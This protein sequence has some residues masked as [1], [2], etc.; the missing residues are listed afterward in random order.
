[1]SVFQVSWTDHRCARFHGLTCNPLGATRTAASRR[2]RNAS[3][4]DSQLWR[5]GLACEAPRFVEAISVAFRPV[6]GMITHMP[7]R[8]LIQFACFCAG[9]VILLVVQRHFQYE[10]DRMMS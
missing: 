7:T 6:N 1:M 3:K 9:L 2:T 8:G 10:L 5:S 4:T